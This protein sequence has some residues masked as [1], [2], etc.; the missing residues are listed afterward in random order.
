M[1]KVDM[2]L[3]YHARPRP[4]LLSQ[5]SLNFVAT[6]GPTEHDLQMILIEKK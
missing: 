1:V 5:K 3:G 6:L 2:N 4:H